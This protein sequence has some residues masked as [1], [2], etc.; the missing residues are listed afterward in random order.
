M[1]R[2]KGIFHKHLRCECNRTGCRIC[3]SRNYMRRKAAE[4]QAN[5][6][7]DVVFRRR[8]RAARV[9]FTGHVTTRPIVARNGQGEASSR[10]RREAFFERRRQEWAADTYRREK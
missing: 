10:Q 7:N 5:P 6:L 2:T 9:D 3:Y 1:G 8:T 4:H